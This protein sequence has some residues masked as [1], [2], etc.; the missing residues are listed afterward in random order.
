TWQGSGGG[1]SRFFTTPD[2]QKGLPANTQQLL[3]G[4]RGV[5]DIASDANPD[6]GLIFYDQGQEE[7]AGGTSAAAPLWAALIAIA[8]QMAGHPLGY[9]NPALYKLAAS[10]A[11]VRDFRDITYGN[12][13]VSDQGVH[14]PGYTAVSGWD[15][16]T[17]LGSPIGEKLLP[18]LIAAVGG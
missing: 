6:S 2:F 9:I 8:D 17:G 4:R 11:Y 10:D 13:A 18:D 5:P 1:F 15:A 14:I 3:A 12:N 7:L 16:V